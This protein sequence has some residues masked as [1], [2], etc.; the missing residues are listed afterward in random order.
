[1]TLGSLAAVGAP[2]TLGGLL[3]G[4]LGGL[5]AG[6]A[7][8]VS[9]RI[10]LLVVMPVALWLGPVAGAVFLVAF[11]SVVHTSGSIPAILLGAPTSAAEAATVIDGYALARRGEG[12]RAIGATLAASGTGGVIGALLLLA[13]AP[14][15]LGAARVIGAPEIALL[16]LLGLLSISA[17]S[18]GRM[19]GGLMLAALG[20]V[21]ATVGVD[22]FSAHE[23]FTFGRLELADGLNAAAVVTG[24][25]VAPELTSAARADGPAAQLRGGDLK[26]VL[27]GFV[28]ALRL[29]WLLLRAS[30]I[31][32][33]VGMAPG[34]GASVA[35]WLAYGHARQTHPSEVPYGEGALAGVVAPEAANNSKEG[36]ALVP[37]LLLGV[38]SSSGMGIL[39]AIFTVL[40]VQVGPLLLQRDPGFIY[41]MGLTNIGSNLLAVPVCLLLAPLMARL[42]LVRREQ[43]APV[44]LAL[45]AVATL[46][47]GPGVSTLLT[48]AAFSLFGI[49]LKAAGLP[50][51]PL[52]LG[53]VL[54]PGL[55]NAGIRAAMIHGWGALQRPGV[56]VILLLA[57]GVL[58]YV[59]AARRRAPAAAAEPAGGRTPALAAALLSGAV[60][61]AALLLALS[62]PEPA[63]GLP[64][65]AAVVGLG[66]ATVSLS[67]ALRAPRPE[68][69]TTGVDLRLLGLFLAALAL[70]AASPP[71]AA[72]A[73]VL[74]AL[75]WLG[76]TGWLQAAAAALPTGLVAWALGGL[77]R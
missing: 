11:H 51:A 72:A 34:L 53:F 59:L 40:G 58:A 49:L 52:L 7:P 14:L 23:R 70:A 24:L 9:G 77:G 55:E 62:L 38:P 35:V 8:G 54:T 25:F 5:L 10:G 48:I 69:R 56:I 2:S 3:L 21:A 36:G 16:S 15:A 76:R 75:G 6:L 57:A 1:M 28:E 46:L 27:A 31:G 44:A 22:P 64:I 13:L 41:L 39:L 60:L 42:C 37:T 63:A 74:A 33:V 71:L 19:A 4:T 73:L 67:A 47:T 20:V 12:A 45:A 32:A 50:R 68:A 26:A 30:L 61:L 43:L 29:R 18:G 66:A 17:L 65:V